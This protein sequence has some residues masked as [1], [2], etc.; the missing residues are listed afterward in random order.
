MHKHAAIYLRSFFP[1]INHVAG[2]LLWSV[3]I[4]LLV[5]FHLQA[6]VYPE[7]YLE[8]ALENNP[9]LQAKQKA[10][11]ASL[12]RVQISGSLPD[13]QLSAGIFTPPMERLM[14]DQY[15]DLGLMQSFPWFGTLDK[16]QAAAEQAAMGK[17]SEFMVERNQLFLRITNLWLEIYNQTRKMD[18]LDDFIRVLNTR[19][20][21]IYSRYGAGQDQPG[22]M[23]DLYRL[24]IQIADLENRKAVLEEE[25]LELTR[26]FNNLIGREELA[27]IDIP[28][29]LQELP[30][31]L[32]EI[33]DHR[34]SF[35]NNPRLLAA[36][37][38][39]AAAKIESDLTRLETRPSFGLGVQ[40]S[41]FGAGD[42]AMG[43][44]DG[45]HMLMPMVSVSIPVFRNKNRAIREEGQLMADQAAY[46]EHNQADELAREWYT[47]ERSLKNLRRDQDF[48]NRQLSITYKTE[49]LVLTGYASGDEGFDEL[50]RIQDQI[51]DLEWRTL[52]VKVDRHKIRAEIDKLKV[53][54][55][56]R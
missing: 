3:S 22:L 27:R 11:E 40:Y 32:P 36:E 30:E 52:E 12:S 56:F 15:L 19:E 49:E 41:W 26:T 2:K 9:A 8:K 7:P 13:P 16:R 53:N 50:L 47:L 42:A 45:G 25:K 23:L 46:A 33:N 4:L 31:D 38:R 37:S 6:Q 5:T 44:M 20:D 18:L 10:Y 54:H 14:G 48:Y 39:T 34:E 43:Q 17:F 51:I 29:S 28:E 35:A 21:I 1:A 24:E 55:V